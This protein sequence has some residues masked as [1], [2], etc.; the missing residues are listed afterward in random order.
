M[1]IVYGLFY[2]S[3]HRLKFKGI[4]QVPIY[5]RFGIGIGKAALFFQI[6][7]LY[8]ALPKIEHGLCRIEIGKFFYLIY[9]RAIRLSY[10][11][12]DQVVFLFKVFFMVLQAVKLD[13]SEVQHSSKYQALCTQR[14]AHSK[15]QDI[16]F[17]R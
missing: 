17:F 10:V 14:L 8:F 9:A 5:L 3:Y 16:S 13:L 15:C 1:Q 7:M 6:L 2:S 12:E 4:D 11:Q